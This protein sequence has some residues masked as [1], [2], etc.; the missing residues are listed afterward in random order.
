MSIRRTVLCGAS[1]YMLHIF[2]MT[3][4]SFPVNGGEG[5]APA[6]PSPHSFLG[7]QQ[8]EAQL[9]HCSALLS[10]GP[11]ESYKIILRPVTRTCNGSSP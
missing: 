10:P 7:T 11:Q 6:R 1:T 8:G 2:W 4:S 9:P 5:G 3:L